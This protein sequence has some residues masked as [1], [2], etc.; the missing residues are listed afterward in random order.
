MDPAEIARLLAD[1]LEAAGFPYA[2]GGALAYGFWGAARGTH[3]VDLNLFLPPDR[4]A[5]ALD[6]LVAAGLL[7]DRA[8]ALSTA[9]QRGDARGLVGSV[10]VDLF[11][12]SIP[13][14]AEAARRVVRV[15]LLGRPAW[16]LSAEDL[17]VFKLPVLSR[18]GSGRHR[19]ADRGARR[20]ARPRLRAPVADRLRR[21]GGRPRAKMGRALRGAPGNLTRAC[22]RARRYFFSEQP[23]SGIR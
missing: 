10:P 4:I 17:T 15:S 22:S 7:I 12:D 11:V 5:A 20:A 21:R 19:A 14:H 18:Q 13:L 2:I 8:A 9:E 23:M 3:D 1:R 6:V 16:I